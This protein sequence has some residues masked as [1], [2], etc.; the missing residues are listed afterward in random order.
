MT[1][2]YMHQQAEEDVQEIEEQEE[3]DDSEAELHQSSEY[4]QHQRRDSPTTYFEPEAK[5]KIDARKSDPDPVY[6]VPQTPAARVK[7]NEPGPFYD[8]PQPQTAGPGYKQVQQKSIPPTVVIPADDN[9]Y[10]YEEVAPPPRS[11]SNSGGFSEFTP[12]QLNLLYN[13]L[14]RM[15]EGDIYGVTARSSSP[16]PRPPQEDLP[17]GDDIVSRPTI[18]PVKQHPQYE[19]EEVVK[20]GEIAEIYDTIDDDDSEQEPTSIN[21]QVPPKP[22][23]RNPKQQ[24]KSVKL[25]PPTAK[26]TQPCTNEEK[27]RT[28]SK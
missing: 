28:I 21:P 5:S 3:I 19:N 27:R 7:T 1:T 4:K 13:L 23:A 8:L 18:L 22:T 16:H 10:V 11:R 15:N 2:S 20:P 17:L 14:K 26:E 9:E 6:D 24:A 25:V 12:E